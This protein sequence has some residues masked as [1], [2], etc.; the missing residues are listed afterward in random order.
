MLRKIFVFSGLTLVL[1]SI[2]SLYSNAFVNLFFEDDPSSGTFITMIFFLLV[3]IAASVLFAFSLVFAIKSFKNEAK[4]KTSAIFLAILIGILFTWSLMTNI[5]SIIT[6][7]NFQ[8]ERLSTRDVYSGQIALRYILIVQ[9]LLLPAL[10]IL[11]FVNFDR[12]KEMNNS[13]PQIEA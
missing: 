5:S 6:L 11:S 1:Q 13:E 12:K 9:S 4:I 2:I 10:S 7:Y 8:K 3:A